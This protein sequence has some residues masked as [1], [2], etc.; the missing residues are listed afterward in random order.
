MSRIKLSL[1]NQRFGKLVAIKP[2]G[3]NKDKKILWLCLCDCG[4]KTIVTGK[5]LKNGHTKSCGCLV[6]EQAKQMGLNNK[7]HGHSQGGK[8]SKIYMV[9]GSMIRRCTN[10]EHKYYSD[11]GG[12]GI[13][14]CGRWMKFPDFLKDMGKDWKSGLTLDREN[15]E[16]GYYKKNCRWVTWKQQ[17]R[18][19]RN[20]RLITYNGKTQLLIEWA[21][22]TGIDRKTIAARIKRGWS[23]EKALTTPV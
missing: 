15:N 10:P 9:W 16:K 4:N 8:R 14:V 11:Y 17:Q 23:I 21:E 22:E 2:R 1:F 20:N 13:T 19:R 12:R 6:L 18:N 7:T 5:S 3:S